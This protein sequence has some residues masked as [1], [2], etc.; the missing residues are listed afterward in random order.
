MTE[1]NRAYRALGMSAFAFTVCFAAWTMNGVLVTFLVDK[2]VYQWNASEMAWLIGIPVLTGAI[3]RM[4]VGILT[5]R[6]GGRIVFALLMVIAAIPMYLV[7][8]ADTYA[9]FFLT[10][11]GYGLSG[12][13]FAAGVAYVSLWFR[14]E[15]QGTALGIFGVGNVGAA[16]TSIAAPFILILVTDQGTNLDG[17]RALPRLYALVLVIT[18]IIFF[19]AVPAKVVEQTGKQTFRQRLAPLKNLRVWRFGLYYSFVLGG[20]VGLSLW[21]V[22]YYVNV[23]SMSLVTAGLIAAIFSLPAA[24]VRVF[25]GWAADNWGARTIMYGALGIGLVCLVLLFVPRMELYLPGESVSARQSG[26]VTAV[27]AHEIVVGE[28]GY[29]L[30]PKL[31]VRGLHNDSGELVLVFPIISTWEEP[32]VQVGDKVEKGQILA[33]GVSHIYFQANVWIFTGLVF[34]VGIMMGMG[35]A[36]T[37][38]H[39]ASYF[40]TSVGVVGGTVG[41]LGA[42]GGFFTPIIFGYLLSA[43]KIWTTTWMFLALIALSCLVWMHLVIRSMEGKSMPAPTRSTEESLMEDSH[44]SEP[45]H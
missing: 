9:Q 30:D 34:I 31:D 21:L 45:L 37:F 35:T 11:L 20:F 8:Y 39:V 23:Y 15:Q 33:R 44:Q 36:A 10:G 3:L 16:L 41:V 32:T 24:L 5:D 27:A 7:S 17:W 2:G 26:V 4:P 1:N 42:L 12:A 13:S 22:P 28:D 25:G 43:T 14:R 38:K 6:Y 18:A 40:P 19:L 29:P